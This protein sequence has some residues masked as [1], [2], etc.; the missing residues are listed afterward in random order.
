MKHIGYS[1]FQVP[2]D[3]P[4]NNDNLLE[5]HE[6]FNLTIMSGLLIIVSVLVLGKLQLLYWIM[7]VSSVFRISFL[8]YL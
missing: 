4:I 3:I 5:R 1:T 7:I 6:T 2:F 8:P